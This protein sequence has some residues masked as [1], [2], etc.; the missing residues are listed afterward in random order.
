M[1]RKHS[2]N[3]GYAIL[4]LVLF[5]FFQLWL[6]WRDVTQLSY[7]DVM[8][9]VGEGKVAS[10]TLTETTIQ[11][12]FKEPQDGRSL[13]IAARVDPASAEAFECQL[14][15]PARLWISSHA[16]RTSEI[17]VPRLPIATRSTI[18]PQSVV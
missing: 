7:S 5:G 9:L 8:R 12:Q 17:R 1:D 15:Q 16:A 6:G 3:I 10:V 13:F 4:A 11:G 2:F 18:F 14:G